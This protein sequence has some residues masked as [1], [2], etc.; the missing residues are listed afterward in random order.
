M[1][2]RSQTGRTEPEGIFLRGANGIL[3]KIPPST[4][5]HFAVPPEELGDA[6]KHLEQ[7]NPL[8]ATQGIAGETGAPVARAYNAAQLPTLMT[9]PARVKKTSMTEVYNAAQFPML[10][11][12]P[13]RVKKPGK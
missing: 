6:L 10:S 9:G 4:I 2:E 8:I 5:S 13:A 11:A 3:Y 1:E 7:I 12:G